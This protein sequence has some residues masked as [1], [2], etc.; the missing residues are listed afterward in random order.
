M[1][2][3]GFSFYALF[4]GANFFKHFFVLFYPGNAPLAEIYPDKTG[5]S[6]AF[7]VTE[8]F[9][10]FLYLVHFTLLTGGLSWLKQ[11]HRV[12]EDYMM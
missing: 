3:S 12:A 7:Q 6:V 11:S 10:Y 9:R 5:K 8:Q 1:E 2:G 4:L